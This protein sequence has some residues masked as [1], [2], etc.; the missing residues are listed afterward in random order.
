MRTPVPAT[1]RVIQA[2]KSI[3]KGRVATYGQIARIAGDPRASRQVVW[4]LKAMSDTERLP[5]HRV[6]NSK[7]RISLNGEGYE[8]QKAMLEDEG[9][10]F[11]STGRV[12]LRLHGWQ[13]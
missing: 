7:G 9:V 11:D 13:T 8:L 6:I 1:A 5:W 4:V 2:I 10:R 12:D 3:P